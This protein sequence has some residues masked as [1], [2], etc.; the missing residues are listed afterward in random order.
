MSTTPG[1]PSPSPLTLPVPALPAASVPDGC[2]AWS[3]EHARR[4]LD[5]LPPR[6]VPLP[7]RTRHLLTALSAAVAVAGLLALLAGWHPW[8]AA[9]LAL[10][11]LWLCARPEIVPVSAPA[12]AVLLAVLRPGT[13]WPE[14]AVAG[15][16]L[17]AVWAAAVLRLVARRRQRERARDA[18]GGATAPLPDAG[19]PLFRGRFLLVCGGVLLALGLGALAVTSA[20]PPDE[21]EAARAIPALAWL[22]AGQGLTTLVSGLLGR[23]RAGALRAA[24]APVLRVLV[25]DGADGDTEV[26]AADD[27]AALRPLF[28]VAV[29]EIRGADAAEGDDEGGEDDET[30]DEEELEEFL[31]RM[32]REGAGPLREAVLYGLPWEG[33]EV[34]LVTAAEEADGQPLL[35]ESSGPVR[36]LSEASLRRVGA[37]EK[38]RAGRQAAYAELRRA[39]GEAVARE[40][41]AEA[42]TGTD[43]AGRAGVR[44]WRAGL[45]DRLCALLLL[46]WGSSLFWGEAGGWHYVLGI[47]AGFIEALWLPHWFAWRITADREGLWLN[48]LRGPR[49]LLWED[50]SVV[51]CEGTE[52]KLDSRRASFTGWSAHTPRWP[53]LERRFG[54]LHPYERTAGEITA[55]WRDPALRPSVSAGRGE[56]GRPLWPLALVLGVAWTAALVFLP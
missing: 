28:R 31:A 24:P 27:T 19:R 2:L 40:A 37:G 55:L 25:R 44:R 4:W 10:H 32:D 26:F 47:V 35:E 11:G 29:T 7:S 38:R 34:L 48:G 23:R 30:D 18:A 56:R 14:T 45:L 49:Q 17:A 33:A 1:R 3:G 9:L 50:I 12:L 54:L 13:T 39:A 20:H 6:W 41:K 53:W 42:E 51:E 16:A 43:G 8:A 22:V 46:L 5:A 52:L 36:P 21:A 15:A